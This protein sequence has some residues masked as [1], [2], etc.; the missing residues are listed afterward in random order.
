MASG[1]SRGPSGEP[2][3]ADN[4]ASPARKQKGTR[5]RIYQ[6]AR[7][8]SHQHKRGGNETKER[9]MSVTGANSGMGPATSVALARQGIHVIMLCRKK[10]RGRRALDGLI[11][12]AGDEG[13]GQQPSSRGRHQ[14]RHRS[15]HRVRHRLRIY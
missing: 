13:G 15:R 11:N 5:S 7:K 2:F 8:G 12:N 4:Q 14:Y 6:Y 9:V 3:C 10:A 1:R